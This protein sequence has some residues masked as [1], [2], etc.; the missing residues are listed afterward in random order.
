MDLGRRGS[1]TVTSNVS[2]GAASILREARKLAPVGLVSSLRHR[3]AAWPRLY[4]TLSHMRAR[5]A[6]MSGKGR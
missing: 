4:Q 5:A 1:P 3:L 6:D 2:G